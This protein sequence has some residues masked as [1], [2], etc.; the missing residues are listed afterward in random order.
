MIHTRQ[1]NAVKVRRGRVYIDK[2][3]KTRHEYGTFVQE[4]LGNPALY[5]R[6]IVK[7][8]LAE[9]GCEGTSRVV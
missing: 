1:G 9:T 3:G 8:A 2:M 5:G 4:S 7:M 6:I